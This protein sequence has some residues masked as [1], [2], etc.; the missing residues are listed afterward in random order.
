MAAGCRRRTLQSPRDGLTVPMS[1]IRLGG[2]EAVCLRSTTGK[3][4]VA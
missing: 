2:R 3:E 1:G 4:L